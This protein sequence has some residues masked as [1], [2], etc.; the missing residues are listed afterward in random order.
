MATRVELINNPYRQQLRILIN[1]A[2]VSVYSNLEKFMDEPFPYWCDKI[3]D[4]IYEEC[5]GGDFSLHFCSRGEELRVME[6]L[7]QD[8]PHCVQYSAGSLMRPASLLDRIKGLNQL[9]RG[10]RESGYRRFRKDILFVIPDALRRLERDLAEL[11]VRNSFCQVDASVVYY[12]DYSRR[13][14]DADMV[15]LVSDQPGILNLA[16]RLNLKEGFGI[17][18]GG[19]TRFREKAGDLFLYESTEQELFDTIFEC[20]LLFP[21]LEMFR[22]CIDTISADIKSQCGERLEELQSIELKVLPQP[23]KTTIEV[24]RSS[25]IQFASDMEGYEVRNTEL[26]FSYSEKGIIR[27]NGLLVEGLK[28]G[29]ATLY[30]YREG[31]QSPCA[32]VAY[33]VIL[34]NRIEELKLEEDFLVIGEG[35][36]ARLNVSYLPVDAD[37]V[38][39]IEWKSDKETIAKVDSS[40][41]VW[42][43]ARGSCTIR[44]FAGQ[45]SARCHCTVKPHLQS[46]SVEE[47]ELE[48]IYGQ[49]KEIKINLKP[50][51]CIDDDIV[52]SSM[53]MRTVNVVGRTLKAIGAGQTRVVIQ[54]SQETVRKEITVIVLTEREYQNRQK[55]RDA[56]SQKGKKKG[57]LSRLFG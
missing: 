3:L 56:G 37:N 57:L 9:V 55:E 5:N 34:R 4:A 35:D 43:I 30:I 29:K 53:D 28:P 46:I 8:C 12:Q 54:N 7:A 51:S 26:H 40:G 14:A 41:G 22:A 47:E 38:D 20:L 17:T 21:L 24:G 49:E 2:A 11:E 15:I 1:G 18:L 39:S 42:G 45:V 52:I 25:R 16:G 50:E 33:C 13:K 44:C 10:A 31:E 27:C 48:M 19:K 32:S 6:R 23:E 36:F